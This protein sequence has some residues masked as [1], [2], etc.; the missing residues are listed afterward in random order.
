MYYKIKI[1]RAC[2]S[3]KLQKKIILK[4]MPLGDKYASKKN[5]FNRFIE[6]NIIECKNCNHLQTST[7]ADAQKLYSKFLS[8]PQAINQ[9]LS[10]DYMDY[11][12]DLFKYINKKDVIV[13]IGSNDGGFLNLFRKKGFKNLVGVEPA[14]NLSHYANKNKIKTIND[15]FSSK[16]IGKI[17]K[18]FNNKAKIV[19][20]NHSL[21]NIH[22]INEVIKN[23]SYILHYKGV[24]SIQT[25]YTVDVIKKKMLENF[26]H[27]HIH[28][29]YVTTINK[30]AKRY[31]LEVFKV[32]GVKAKGG[33][34]RVYI[35]HN[36]MQKIH[37]SVKLF[38]NKE[39]KF[40][41]NKKIIS[42]IETFIKN[43]RKNITKII[44]KNNFKKIIGYG[45]SIG[46]TTFLTQYN[47]SKYI[48][49][50]VD[51]DKYRQRKFS[52]GY[53]IYV[54]NDKI[55]NIFKPDLIII[56][57]PLY[58]K[59]IMNKIKNK[60]GIIPLLAIWPKVKLIKNY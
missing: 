29:F 26:N 11:A 49:Y 39:K 2:S 57:A 34:I 36:G 59:K 6:I 53:N 35:G 4:P 45:T 31:G 16:V 18:K 12:K 42:K 3:K 48:K 50:F 24:Y 10:K 47:L 30:I 44:K 56:F 54:T 1:C 51:D 33:S 7:T 19:I 43:N 27:E 21:S 55:I 41:K 60:F 14:K 28:Y 38:I 46:A 58:I 9:N 52:P 15:F 40:F 23:V 17:Y 32:F 8:R 5:L 25:F 13:D 20:N 22:N 37:S